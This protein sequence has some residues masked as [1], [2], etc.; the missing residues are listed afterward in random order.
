MGQCL[1]NED[2]SD[3]PLFYSMQQKHPIKV[4]RK[5]SRYSEKDT[6]DS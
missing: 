2:K 5:W 4:G 6:F 3:R 1:R